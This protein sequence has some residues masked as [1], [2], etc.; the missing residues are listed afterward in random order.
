MFLTNNFQLELSI[1]ALSYNLQ[2]ERTFSWNVQ[3]QLPV[4]H[5]SWNIQLEPSVETPSYNFPLELSIGALS[6]NFQLE[7]SVGT[8]T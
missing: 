5:L 4:G 1:G 3:L 8:F 6:Y 7:L 2:L